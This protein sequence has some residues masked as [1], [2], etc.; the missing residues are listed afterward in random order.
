M[1]TATALCPLLCCLVLGACYSRQPLETPL[2]TPDT[3]IVATLT[4]AGA[5][6]LGESLGAGAV[7]VEG[8]VRTATD[9][10]WAL[11]M[12]RVEHRAGQN[13]SWNRELVSFPREALTNPQVVRLDH[14]RSWL[15]AGGAVVGT[16]L[17]ARAFNVFGAGEE[18][19]DGGG[20]PPPHSIL[21]GRR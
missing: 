11:H 5:A 9:S 14:T 17:L 4:D 2:P 15:A 12:L 20:M 10:V 6:A 16:F 7:E 18:D 3:R 8:V 13:Y 21:P 19:R 1:K